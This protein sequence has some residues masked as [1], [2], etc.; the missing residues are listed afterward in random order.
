[1]TEECINP[2]KNV[3]IPEG[4]EECKAILGFDSD[5]CLRIYECDEN[6]DVLEEECIED[7]IV[8]EYQKLVFFRKPDEVPDMYIN[9][10]IVNA[11]GTVIPYVKHEPVTYTGVRKGDMIDYTPNSDHLLATCLS[12]PPKSIFDK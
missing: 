7:L 4:H 5:G 8:G 10:F 2:L 1:M 12:K 9:P 3:P 6:W 11:E